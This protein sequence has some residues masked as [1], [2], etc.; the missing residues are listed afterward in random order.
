MT[1]FHCSNCHRPYLAEGAPYCCPH[2]GGVYSLAGP[3]TFSIANIEPDLPGLWRYRHSFG[4]P[5]NA[6][7]I[8]LGEGD[9]PLV[10]GQ[11]F[12][13][14]IA[15]KL[16]F[17]NPTGSFKD[18]ATAPLASFLAARG[19]KEAVEDSSGNA[20]ASF[21]A[22]AARAGIR[23]RVFVPDYAS[24]P[25]RRQIEAYGAELVP[26]RGPRSEA[27][28]AVRKAAEEGTVY[29]SHAYLPIGLPGIATIAYELFE[30]LGEAPGSIIAPVG[31]GSLLLGIALGFDALR[32]TG[33]IKNQPR[34]IGVQARACAPL[35]ALSTQGAAGLAWVTE[36]ETLAEGVR[37]LQPLRGD[38]LLRAVEASSGRF[39]AVEEEK[40]LSARDSLAHAGLFVEPTSAVVWA[41]LQEIA[42]ELPE[43]IVLVLSGSGLK[44]L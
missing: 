42:T 38:E 12:G 39:V 34:L 21:A 32:A 10:E 15:F 2:C 44:A 33:I 40:I 43:P 13:R 6:P 7:V 36:G 1:N 27:A 8:H 4:L 23:G 37:V 30:D 22:Y 25:K 5:Q 19:V 17:L 18:R 28:A 16:E 11:G 9:T 35:W 26:V 24:G 29:A 41:A 31:H 3:I 14:K 20:G